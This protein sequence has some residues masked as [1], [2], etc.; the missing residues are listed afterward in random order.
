MPVWEWSVGCRVQI[1]AETGDRDDD[2]TTTQ[3]R[4]ERETSRKSKSSMDALKWLVLVQA[5]VVA[6]ARLAD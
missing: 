3:H 1:A 4:R 2:N 6:V 5:V